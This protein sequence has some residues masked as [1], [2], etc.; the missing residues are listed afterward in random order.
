MTARIAV[1]VPTANRPQLLDRCLA[2]LVGQRLDEP[3]EI[4]VAD[5]G[6]SLL[7]R[8]QAGRWRDRAADR[9]VRVRYVATAGG[10]G[11]ATARNLGWRSTP[12]QY[13]AFTDDDCQPDGQWLMA[14]V[15]HLQRGVGL[16]AGR[17]V[18]PTRER[19]TDYE[20]NA[21]LLAEAGF[22]TA[23]CFASRDALQSIGGFDERFRGAWR[24]DSDLYFRAIRK[25]V[26][27]A[28]AS[29]AVVLHPIRPAP[30]GIS[31]R[32][33]RNS[34]DNALLYREHPTLYRTHIQASPPWRYYRAVVAI[35]ISACALVRGRR[36]AAM[37]SGAWWLFETARFAGGR[38]RGASHR[39]AHVAEMVTTSALI[40]PLAIFWRLRGAM[41]HR[42]LFM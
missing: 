10:R 32:Q 11:P 23:S 38:L 1:V 18:V 17:V 42:V 6:T 31:L 16:V 19:P 3:F 9:G 21:G 5:D 22:V 39:P 4:V 8:E 36:R 26:V 30:W 37:V 7:T 24:E 12:A 25:N 40:P 13:V 34:I 41:R 35:G 14:G 33:Q 29:E 2:A 15:A 28:T 27:V 20:R